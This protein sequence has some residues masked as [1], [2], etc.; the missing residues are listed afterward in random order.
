MC[1][2][3]EYR[4]TERGLNPLIPRT[5]TPSPP[6]YYLPTG[7]GPRALIWTWNRVL[8]YVPVPTAS[9]AP[10][11]LTRTL[12][13]FWCGSYLSSSTYKQ[14]MDNRNSNRLKKYITSIFHSRHKDDAFCWFSWC[15]R[16]LLRTKTLKWSWVNRNY[17]SNWGLLYARDTFHRE[18]HIKYPHKKT[19][20]TIEKWRIGSN[21]F[22]NR[23]TLN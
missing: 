5:S 4:Q 15:N 10:T 8:M 3:D 11:E 22:E 23:I 14:Q 19:F 20:N 17:L 7:S 2:W 18:L 9:S 13:W 16:Y 21:I 1:A 12:F 6:L